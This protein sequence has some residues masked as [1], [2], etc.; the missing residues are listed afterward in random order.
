MKA[1][2]EQVDQMPY[3]W[4]EEVKMDPKFDERREIFTKIMIELDFLSDGHF[5]HI[6][7]TEHRTK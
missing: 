1:K 5:S 3:E 4:K 7:V 2:H 6:R